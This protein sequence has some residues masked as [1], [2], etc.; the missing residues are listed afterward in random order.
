MQN[1]P[2]RRKY[3][4]LRAR[5]LYPAGVKPPPPPKLE[6]LG[7]SEPPKR[8]HLAQLRWDLNCAL[9]YEEHPFGPYASQG[10]AVRAIIEYL[11]SVLPGSSFNDVEPL[12]VLLIILGDLN[13][14]A[15]RL[16]P[17]GGNRHLRLATDLKARCLVISELLQKGGLEKRAA[18]NLVVQR[19]RT[20]ASALDCGSSRSGT[21]MKRSRQRSKDGGRPNDE[22]IMGGSQKEETA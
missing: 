2:V 14:G 3:R 15:L 5:R 20:L 1:D 18:D 19:I 4:G 13:T 12:E 16:A 7:P 21:V 8:D 10:S 17:S 6:L 11:Q 9:D 22:T